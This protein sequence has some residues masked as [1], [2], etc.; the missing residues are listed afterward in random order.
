[1][2]QHTN[3]LIALN[4]AV[5]TPINEGLFHQIVTY[6]I[7]Q[8]VAPINK[9]TST[10]LITS[11]AVPQQGDFPLLVDA[12]FGSLCF[13]DGGSGAGSSGDDKDTT[14]KELQAFLLMVK[15]NVDSTAILN[16]AIGIVNRQ[17]MTSLRL[18]EPMEAGKSL[19]NYGLDSLAAVE[20]RNWAR[21]E[22][23]SELTTLEVTNATSLVALCE[24]IISKIAVS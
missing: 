11:I 23:G 15:A 1:M 7:R 3:L 16:A 8:Q 2:S 6:S 20:F 17:F 22:L 18:S 13:S 14:K 21:M 19:A 4:P 9:P 24:K 12:R 5:W 10:Q